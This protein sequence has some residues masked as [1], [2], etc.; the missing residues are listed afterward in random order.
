MRLE[1]TGS[2]EP[3]TTAGAG[4]VERVTQATRERARARNP[5][6]RSVPSDGAA[7]TTPAQLYDTMVLSTKPERETGLEP[8]TFSL[9]GRG[10][11]TLWHPS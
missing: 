8:A 4:A 5:R 2:S 9:E 7:R 1:L 6:E 3:E 10:G 11:C